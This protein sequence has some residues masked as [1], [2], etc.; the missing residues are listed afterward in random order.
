MGIIYNMYV[1]NY[2]LYRQI[3]KKGGLLVLFFV[4]LRAAFDSVD[5]SRLLVA[6]RER[7]V[8]KGLV[9]RCRITKDKC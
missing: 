7:G 9:R 6:L 8:K 5:R 2:L 3:S 1:L 4:N